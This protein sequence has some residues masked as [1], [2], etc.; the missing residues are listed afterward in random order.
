VQLLVIFGGMV[1]LVYLPTHGVLAKLFRAPSP[2]REPAHS[3]R[4]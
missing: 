3:A 2:V 4:A 1:L